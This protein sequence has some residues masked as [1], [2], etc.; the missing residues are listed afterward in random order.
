[1]R[2]TQEYDL[3]PRSGFEQ[4]KTDRSMLRPVTDVLS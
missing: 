1:M 3:D 4:N 2:L